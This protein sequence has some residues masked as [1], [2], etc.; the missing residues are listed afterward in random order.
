MTACCCSLCCGVAAMPAPARSKFSPRYS[1]ARSW[2]LP[3]HS[4]PA[5]TQSATSA[6]TVANHAQGNAAKTRIAPKKFLVQVSFGKEGT[7]TPPKPC[8]KERNCIF[9]HLKSYAASNPKAKPAHFHGSLIATNAQRWISVRTGFTRADSPNPLSAAPVAVSCLSVHSF[10][11]M[12][13]NDAAPGPAARG[14]F[15]AG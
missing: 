2:P 15:P 4:C 3:C 11:G 10:P 8:R 12:R 9:L 5:K 6:R 14:H 13:A 1:L 7:A